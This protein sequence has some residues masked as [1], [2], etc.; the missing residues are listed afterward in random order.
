MS[1]TKQKAIIQIK[2][3]FD[4]INST[5]VQNIGVTVGLVNDNMFEWQATIIG[6]ADTPYKNGLFI[7]N[8]KFPDN[9]PE[10]APEVCFVTP[11]YHLNVN[12]HAPKSSGYQSLGHVCVST[13]NDWKSG[14]KMREV[15]TNIFALFYLANPKSPYGMDRAE[16]MLKNRTLYDEK[17]KYF[18]KKYA[19]P[20]K[21]MK[22]YDTDW[23][24]SY[25]K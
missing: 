8:I 23:D 15:L 24:F 11:I 7:L 9:Y 16:E 10:S 1:Q 12:P 18:T 2:K 22:K 13:L 14:C 20:R 6:P 25:V 3:E 21:A 4:D 19:N 17:V 5:P